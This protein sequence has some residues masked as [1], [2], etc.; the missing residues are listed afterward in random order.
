MIL[1]IITY[2][3]L[4][5]LGVSGTPKAVGMLYSGLPCASTAYIL[6]KQLGGDTD[7]MAS[8]I[9]VTTVISVFT[10]SIILYFVG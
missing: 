1:P 6:A 9:T 4:T 10:L 5:L 8:I 2:I 3:I 7:L